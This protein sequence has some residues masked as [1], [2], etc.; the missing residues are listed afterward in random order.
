MYKKSKSVKEPE[1]FEKGYDYA[2]F[3][4]SLRLRTTGEI[5]EKMKNRGY[6]LA[7]SEKVIADL[8]EQKFLD[9]QKYAEIFLDNLKKYKNFGFYGIKKKM[10]EKRLPSSIIDR[11]LEEGLLVDEEIKIAERL[12]E[13]FTLSNA[14]KRPRQKSGFNKAENK[15]IAQRLSSRGFR[16]E[17]LARILFE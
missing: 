13:K 17:V 3:L 2:V 12:L 4:L 6:T 10:M 7:V 11:V 14:A 5:R 1:N 16:S 15:K 8:L 9:D